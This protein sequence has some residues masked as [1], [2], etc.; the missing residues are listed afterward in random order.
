MIDVIS[1]T[2]LTQRIR[3]PKG[4][5]KRQKRT[6]GALIPMRVG[7]RQLSSSTS[8]PVAVTLQLERAPGR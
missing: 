2:A 5:L 4:K 6:I 8:D 1:R 7:E 3:T